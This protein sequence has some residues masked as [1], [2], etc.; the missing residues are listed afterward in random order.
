MHVH[1]ALSPKRAWHAGHVGCCSVAV[2]AG[3]TSELS[4]GGVCISSVT[5]LVYSMLAV[6]DID[7]D[8]A[9]EYSRC[10]C[11]SVAKW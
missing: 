3:G 2:P 4:S 8:T 10:Y 5:S 1:L 9:D 7:I 11:Y 6:E